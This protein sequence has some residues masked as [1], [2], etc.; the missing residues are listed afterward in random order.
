MIKNT[1]KFVLSNNNLIIGKRYY[2]ENIDRKIHFVYGKDYSEIRGK[3]SFIDKFDYTKLYLRPIV[4]KNNKIVSVIL[5]YSINRI[6]MLKMEQMP[7]HRSG[8]IYT[9]VFDK[10]LKLIKKNHIKKTRR[11]GKLIKQASW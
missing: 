8:R 4:L 6:L 2:F 10:E 1:L 5:S 9:K 11:K 7:Q 3:K